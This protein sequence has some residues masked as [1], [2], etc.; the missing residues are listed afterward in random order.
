[1]LSGRFVRKFKRYFKK[2]EGLKKY[3]K[4]FFFCISFI[5]GYKIYLEWRMIGL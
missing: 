4:S 3:N 1:M 2:G 5:N